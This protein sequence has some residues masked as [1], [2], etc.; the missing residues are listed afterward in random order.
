MEFS[1]ILAIYL[2]SIEFLP[3]LKACLN[4]LHYKLLMGLSH[5]NLIVTQASCKK[6]IILGE[7]ISVG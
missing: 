6:V 5:L 1:L 4:W 2:V 7:D 3:E